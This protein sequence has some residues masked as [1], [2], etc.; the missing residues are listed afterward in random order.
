MGRRRWLRLDPRPGFADTSVAEVTD[1]TSPLD[2]IIFPQTKRV[3]LGSQ[4]GGSR[5]PRSPVRKAGEKA[6]RIPLSGP[7]FEAFELK[8]RRPRER[9]AV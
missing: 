9:M 7:A 6:A 8:G 5:L 1:S 3:A 4:C 2:M